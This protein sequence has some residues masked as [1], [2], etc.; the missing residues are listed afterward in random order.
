MCVWEWG[1]CVCAVPLP[2]VE[3]HHVLG[4]ALAVHV[5]HDVHHRAGLHQAHLFKIKTT[6]KKS[7]QTSDLWQ[8]PWDESLPIQCKP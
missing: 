8:R 5:R 2:L 6:H 4:L 3:G 7:T 1:V